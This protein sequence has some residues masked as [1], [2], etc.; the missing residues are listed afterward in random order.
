MAS[1]WL[2]RLRLRGYP[3]SQSSVVSLKKSLKPPGTS[4][5]IDPMMAYASAS[6]AWLVPGRAVK[7]MV[8]VFP[9]IST[10]HSS[11]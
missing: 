9:P 7:R 10:I 4:A 6:S 2:G 3:E 5:R 1:G 8:I 11:C